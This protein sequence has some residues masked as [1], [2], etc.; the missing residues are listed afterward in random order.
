MKYYN[1]LHV[2]DTNS[3]HLILRNNKPVLLMTS[4]I[5]ADKIA[6]NNLD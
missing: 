3:K 2:L 1:W 4:V 6:N 5:N